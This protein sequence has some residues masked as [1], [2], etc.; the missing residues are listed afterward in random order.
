[1]GCRTLGLF[2]RFLAVAGLLEAKGRAKTID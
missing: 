2:L 1:V